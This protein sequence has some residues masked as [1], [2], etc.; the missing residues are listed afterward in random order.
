[1]VLPDPIANAPKSSSGGV[2][3]G[4]HALASGLAVRRAPF[5]ADCA[6]HVV[7]LGSVRVL[8]TRPSVIRLAEHSQG[9]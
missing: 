6:L 3:F 9:S 8:V 5:I 1:M 7:L 4:E 2:R